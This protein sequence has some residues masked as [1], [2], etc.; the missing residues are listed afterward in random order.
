MLYFIL[1]TDYLVIKK[2][3]NNFVFLM[4]YYYFINILLKK[5]IIQ[6][7]GFDQTSDKNYRFLGYMDNEY[8]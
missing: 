3:K 1:S 2:F 6:F 7:Y 5:E 8:L 4:K